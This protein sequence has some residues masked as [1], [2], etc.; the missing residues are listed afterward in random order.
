M[1]KNIALLLFYARENRNSFNAILGA[2]ETDEVITK[3]DVFLESTKN[4]L[5]SKLDAIQGKYSKIILGVS[6]FTTQLWEINELI[7]EI[8]GRYGQTVFIIAGGPH[9]TGDPRRTLQLGIN[10][11][12]VGEGEDSFIE[13]INALN[14]SND[15]KKIVGL[16]FYDDDGKYLFTGKRQLLNLNKYPPFPLMNM[17]FG[18]I[19]ITRGCPYVCYFCQTPYLFGTNPRHR[20]IEEICKYARVMKEN[21]MLD[22]RFISPNAFSYG[23]KDGKEL[24]LPVIEKLLQ[25]IKLILGEGGRVF[26]GSFPSEVRPEHVNKETIRLVKTYAS[27]DNITIGAQSG[28]QNILDICNR[29]HSTEDVYEAVNLTIASGLEV[30]VDF[31]FGLPKETKEDIQATLGMMEKL[32]EMGAQ[33]HTHTFMP[34][35]QTPFAKQ[36]VKSLDKELRTVINVLSSKGQAFG[37]WKKQEELAIKIARYLKTGEL[38]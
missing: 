33:I 2:L 1:S 37:Q 7:K 26:F 22:V 10:I 31:I 11:V 25:E 17:K 28:S 29:G 16:A 6:I 24:N 23:S 32:A 27:N 8:R 5:L 14:S 9:S 3:V 38:E 21:N 20:S 15:F 19:E 36:P 18:A 12:V 30:N 34:L 4:S 35:P 13:L